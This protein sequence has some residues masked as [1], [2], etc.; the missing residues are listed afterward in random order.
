MLS[1]G[2]SG[3]RIHQIPTLP[4]QTDI[5]HTESA[6]QLCVWRKSLFLVEVGWGKHHPIL[7]DVYTGSGGHSSGAPPLS[8]KGVRSYSSQKHMTDVRTREA[9]GKCMLGGG[10]GIH[11][12]EWVGE[13]AREEGGGC[14]PEKALCMT[15]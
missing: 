14:R 1:A 15:I 11:G 12:C 13:W 8:T 5:G 3:T 4:E 7:G 2:R 9:Q 6:S 10:G